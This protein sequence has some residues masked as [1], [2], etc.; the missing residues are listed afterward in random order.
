MRC[1]QPARRPESR[2]RLREAAPGR[3]PGVKPA[4]SERLRRTTRALCTGSVGL[5]CKEAKGMVLLCC[6]FL[7]GRRLE[8]AHLCKSFFFLRFYLFI[9]KRHTERGKDTGRGRS[10]LHAGIPLWDSIPGLQGH[11]LG[12]R[13]ALNRGATQGSPDSSVLPAGSRASLTGSNDF[14]LSGP[15]PR[16]Q[17]RRH[18]PASCLSRLPFHTGHFQPPQCPLLPPTPGAW[19]RLFPPLAPH[20]HALA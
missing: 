13:Q 10:R 16:S 17:S 11:A 1:V 19:H 15:A 3:A 9:H 6:C 14:L 8:F 12:Q 5:G 18:P 2:A 7:W 4:G 20:P